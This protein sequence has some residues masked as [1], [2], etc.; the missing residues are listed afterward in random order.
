MPKRK[1]RKK[2][3]QAQRKQF[4]SGFDSL[5]TKGNMKNTALETGKDILV[6]VLGGGLIGAAIGRPSLAIGVVTTGLGHYSG[7]KLTQLLGL[8]MMAAN[9]FQKSNSVN[10]FEGFDGVKDRL[11]A[12]KENFSEKLYIDKL[13]KKAS[14]GAATS[15]FGNLQY[16]S[17]PNNDLAALNAIEEQ[18]ANSAY[19]F[20]GALP[21][22]EFGDVDRDFGEVSNEFG[23]VGSEFGDL[24][25]RMF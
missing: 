8:G 20:Q 2:T 15:G 16:F 13:M 6:C 21:D 24:E 9:G 11:Q 18:V 14:A 12:Y 10:G 17:Y 22:S 19:Q 1:T 25:E 23:D 5:A 7:N 4:T 3:K